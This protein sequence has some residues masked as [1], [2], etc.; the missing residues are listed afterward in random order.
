LLVASNDQRAQYSANGLQYFTIG[1]DSL[2]L[3][4]ELG[5]E[6]WGP[7]AVQWIGTDTVLIKREYLTPVESDEVYITDVV[8]M[9]IKQQKINL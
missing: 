7:A 1:G 9:V 3:Q 8:R 2:T 4:W 5:L 6:N